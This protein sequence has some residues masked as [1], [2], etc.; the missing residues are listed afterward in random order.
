MANR[1]SFVIVSAADSYSLYRVTRP[2]SAYMRRGQLGAVDV[3]VR[4]FS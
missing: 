2:E 4:I 3:D 1:Q